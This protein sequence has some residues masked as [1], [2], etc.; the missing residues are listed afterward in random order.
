MLELTL[1]KS[2]TDLEIE[3]LDLQTAKRPQA[4]VTTIQYLTSIKIF[5]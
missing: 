1:G 2:I 4:S 3:R 5:K